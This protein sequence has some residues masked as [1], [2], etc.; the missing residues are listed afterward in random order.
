MSKP[1]ASARDRA[2]GPRQDWIAT[3]GDSPGWIASSH[4]IGDLPSARRR[5]TT[6]VLNAACSPSV[7]APSGR[8]T[9]SPPKCTNR[10]GKTS[11]SS[12][13]MFMTACTA[14]GL[15][16][17]RQHEWTPKRRVGAATVS[18]IPH[19]G[20]TASQLATCPGTSSSGT[21]R[22]P[23]SA[24]ARTSA[25]SSPGAYAG[26]G[27]ASSGYACDRK[28]KAWSSERCRCSTFSLNSA[29]ASSVCS[30]VLMPMKCRAVS[31]ISPRQ[32][33]R[34]AS[35]MVRTGRE[36]SSGPPRTS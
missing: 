32:A 14:S 15:S 21:I 13:K 4:A 10:S 33:N 34:G 3:S 16:G 29:M 36:G 27:S 11:A 2:A 6:G 23:R 24:A 35:S 17:S 1:A 12:P 26:C 19:S 7:S 30:S 8:C 25:R 5:A 28:R 9:S 20:C 18:P 31:T 22:M